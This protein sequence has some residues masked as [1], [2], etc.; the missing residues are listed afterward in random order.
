MRETFRVLEEA[1]N[2]RGGPSV[3]YIA[4]ID[5][6]DYEARVKRYA[7]RDQNGSVNCK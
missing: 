3:L 6:L 1:R 7:H 2:Q 5:I 4:E